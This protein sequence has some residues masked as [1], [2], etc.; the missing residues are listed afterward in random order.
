MRPYPLSPVAVL[1]ICGCTP[2][3]VEAP[4]YAPPLD[5]DTL[6]ITDEQGANVPA[7]LDLREGQ[8]VERNGA[9]VCEGYMTRFADENYCAAEPPSEWRAFEFDGQT[10]Y[11]QPLSHQ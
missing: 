3:S 7:F 6:R 4:A 10:W 1:L 5:P 2:D 11:M 8:W 9:L